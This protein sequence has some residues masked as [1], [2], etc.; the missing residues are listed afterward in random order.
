MYNKDLKDYLNVLRTREPRPPF[1][2]MARLVANA[3]A[4]SMAAIPLH[5]KL[6]G[7]VAILGVVASGVWLLSARLHAVTVPA[8]NDL[9]NAGASY[10][11][12]ESYGSDVAHESYGSLSSKFAPAKRNTSQFANSTEPEGSV[13]HPV[14]DD[15]AILTLHSCAIREQVSSIQPVAANT[16]LSSIITIPSS[17]VASMGS[18]FAT[19]GGAVSQ[20]FTAPYQQTSF[21]DAFLGVGYSISPNSSLRM[22]IGEEVFSV[23]SS[24]TT[25]SISFH[26]TTFVNNGQSS[27]N[28]LGEIK[29]VDPPALMRVYWLGAIYRTQSARSPR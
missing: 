14:N 26:D 6:A 27:Q 24:T 25:N 4:R 29:S 21:T 20:Q 12:R 18:F 9:V 7:A 22:L 3:P 5:E 28:V 13:L 16:H 19:F 8:R 11:P 15:N 17:D 10:L 1:S 2:E 23:P